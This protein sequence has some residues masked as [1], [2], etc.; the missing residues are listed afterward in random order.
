MKVYVKFL[1]QI[2]QEPDK[3]KLK[4]M[5][6]SFSFMLFL[7]LFLMSQASYNLVTS[8]P[9]LIPRS[10]GVSTGLRPRHIGF[11]CICTRI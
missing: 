6:F 9:M 5:K 4:K 8:V 10:G 1:S 11:L 7:F 3:Q 2:A